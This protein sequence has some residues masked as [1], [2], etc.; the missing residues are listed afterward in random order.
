MSRIVLDAELR[1]K[2][3]GAGERI[4]FT[5]ESGNVVGCYLP[6]TAFD[7][8]ASQL[9]APSSPEQLAEAR[10]EMLE[11]GGVSGDELRARLAEIVR[12]WEARQ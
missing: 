6:Q 12:R 7:Q 4:E 2:L 1:A 3:R 5:D 10:R 9:L 8:I 11:R